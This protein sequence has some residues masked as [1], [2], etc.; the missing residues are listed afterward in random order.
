MRFSMANSNKDANH[1]QRL[2]QV[3]ENELSR[4]DAEIE[5]KKLEI[6]E[7]QELQK[8][9]EEMPRELTRDVL[10][11]L[12]PVAFLPGKITQTNRTMVLLGDNYF[13]DKS[14]FQ[15]CEMIQRR[16]KCMFMFC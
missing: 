14:C 9:L 8:L 13:V 11:P 15:A 4:L 2:K 1:L 3:L 12:S 10:V 6:K 5:Q 16:I 7:Y